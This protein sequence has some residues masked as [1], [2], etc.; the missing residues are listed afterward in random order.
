MPDKV[1]LTLKSLLSKK[2]SD[3]PC[4]TSLLSQIEKIL[5]TKSSFGI[6]SFSTSTQMYNQENKN[7]YF[8]KKGNILYKILRSKKTT[9][10][11]MWENLDFAT[12]NSQQIWVKTKEG[13]IY[14]CHK[15]L[16]Y[17]FTE[18]LPCKDLKLLIPGYNNQVLAVYPHQLIEFKISHDVL[19]AEQLW[20][21][22]TSDV[23]SRGTRLAD[24]HI[25]LV[26]NLASSQI[27]VIK[28]GK[29]INT[30]HLNG[31][32]WDLGY[33]PQQNIVYAKMITNSNLHGCCIDPF[34][35][36]IGVLKNSRNIMSFAIDSHNGSLIGINNCGEIIKW[37]N[38]NKSETLHKVSNG[39]IH[40][41]TSNND[42]IA[43][44]L[45]QRNTYKIMLLDKNQEIICDL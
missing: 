3:R 36:D 45:L 18:V 4:A 34:T 8:C 15:N 11:K 16:D 38:S 42:A 5:E 27:Q 28:Q 33:W 1:I 25:V 24:N 6:S 44:L 2:P 19:K 7:Q 13:Y 9:V 43:A 32:C 29:I 26:K 21:M 23:Y 10:S 20:S 31:L 35:G 12:G 40:A 17:N 41:F 37:E 39:S 30:I 22:K 14:H